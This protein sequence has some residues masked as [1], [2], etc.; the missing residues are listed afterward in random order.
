MA[1]PPHVDPGEVLPCRM[2]LVTG[3]P[4]GSDQCRFRKHDLQWYWTGAEWRDRRTG[5]PFQP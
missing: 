1:A 4:C 3:I 2:S 5:Q